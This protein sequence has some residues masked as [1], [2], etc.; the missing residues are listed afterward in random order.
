M[1]N[2]QDYHL[3]TMMDKIIINLFNE[4]IFCQKCIDILEIIWYKFSQMELSGTK[5]TQMDLN[6]RKINTFYG[7]KSKTSEIT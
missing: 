3:L 6:A 5:W 7:R 1:I 2:R 4:F